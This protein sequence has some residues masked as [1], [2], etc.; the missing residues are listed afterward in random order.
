MAGEDKEYEGEVRP[1]K[2]IK[3]GY[4]PQEPR[5]SPEKTVNEC[6]EEGVAESRAI[7]DHYN[8]LNMKLCEELTPDEMEKVLEDQAK[9]QDKIDAL[10]LWELD[11]SVDIAADAVK[12]P[13]GRCHHR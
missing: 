1:A 11:R 2:G 9:V 3:I 6:I 13:A 10:N 5:L 7:L 12:V 4:F 8:D